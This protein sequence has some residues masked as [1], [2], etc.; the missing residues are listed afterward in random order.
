MKEKKFILIIFIMVFG[1]NALKAEVRNKDRQQQKQQQQQQQESEIKV[2]AQNQYMDNNK[3]IASGDV[4]IAWEDYRIFCEYLE[5]NQDTKELLAKGRITMSSKETVLTG[6]RLSFNLKTREGEI[7]DTYGQMPPT[8]RYTTDK[9]TQVDNDT[10]TFNKLDFTSCTQCLPRWKFSCT[11]GKIKKEKYIEMT[12]LLFKI[13]KIPIFYLPY[14]RYPVDKDGRATGILMPNFGTSSIRGFFLLNAFFWAIKPNVDLTLYFDYYARAGIGLAQEFRYL[15]N[16]MDGNIKFYL[17]NYKKG[18]IVG[19]EKSS[20]YYLKMEHKQRI[21]FLN[22]KITIAVD[23]QSDANFLRLFSNDFDS[24]LTRNSRSMGSIDSSF[25]NVKISIN[26]MRNDTYYTFVN[27]S[28]SI[29]YL[30][31]IKI[32]WNQQKLGKLPGYFSLGV[33]Y[34]TVN[35]VG[36]SYDADDLIYVSDVSSTRLNLNPSYM[37]G[38][39]RFPWLN[40]YLSMETNFTYYPKSKDPNSTSKDIIILDEPLKLYYHS[41]DLILKGPVF[42]KIFESRYSKFKHVIEPKITIKYVTK[43]DEEDKKRLI[44]VD[45]FDFPS[46]SFVGFSLSTRILHKSKNSKSSPREILSYTISQDYYFDP[47]LANRGRNIN[48]VF[49]EFSQLDNTL[50]LRPFKDFSFDASLTFNHYL[51][52]FT[53]TRIALSYRNPSS[54]V[55]GDFYYNANVNQYVNK[56]NY[57]LNR[58]IIGGSLNINIPRFPLIFNS[59]VNYDITDREFRLASFRLTYDY[60][61]IQFRSELKLFKYSGRVETQFNAGVSFGNLGMVKDFLGIDK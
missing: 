38:L 36:I 23:R 4:E 33:V 56:T 1:L 48:G 55:S 57:I 6:E 29:S 8:I 47:Q 61:C 59:N 53:N 26:G 52:S 30:P 13:K 34:A 41:A 7:Y 31:Q 20:D 54:P 60:Q 35:R 21:N 24:V 11:K 40:A 3:L 5:F 16:Q 37:L 12:N 2:D 44:P 50:R 42:S 32:N 58:K 25:A 14:V 17:F 45:Y 28:T 51:K 46:Y 49:P 15:T 22:T 43:V 27:R 18:N 9:L 10:L 39:L 19:A